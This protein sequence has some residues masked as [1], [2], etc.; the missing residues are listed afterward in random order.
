[1]AEAEITR[2]YTRL[3][4]ISEVTSWRRRS[5]WLSQPFGGVDGVSSQRRARVY[6]QV[7]PL[8]DRLTVFDARLPHGVE[9]AE[10]GRD[11][12]SAELSRAEPRGRRVEGRGGAGPEGGPAGSARLVHGAGPVLRGISR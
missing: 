8:F 1:M 2:D 6:A 7:Q 5:R 3:A 9:R 11:P 4:E 12:R 10:G